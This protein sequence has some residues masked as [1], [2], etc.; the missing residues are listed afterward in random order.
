MS[1]TADERRDEAAEDR[2][3]QIEGDMWGEEPDWDEIKD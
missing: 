2:L 3:D 1:Q